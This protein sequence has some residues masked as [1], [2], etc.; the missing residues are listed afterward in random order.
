MTKTIQKCEN[1]AANIRKTIIQMAEY[2]DGDAHWGSALSCV[3]V[4]TVLYNNILNCKLKDTLPSQKDKFILS[5]GHAAMALYAT[6]VEVQIQPREILKNFQQDGSPLGE[7]AIMN[8]QYG[9][10]CSGGSLGLG[11]PMGVGLALAGKRKHMTYQTYVLVGD[12]EM[13][14]GSNWEALMA[15]SQFELDNLTLIIDKNGFQS[16]GANKSI[17]SMENI[18]MKLTAFGWNTTTVNGHSYKELLDVFKREK[19]INQPRAIVVETV[20]GKGISFMEND[21]TWH[22]EILQKDLLAQA[23]KEV[24]CN[25]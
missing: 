1:I 15:A 25:N 7:L 4:L 5:K 17:M 2:C 19:K 23:K 21:N 18:E 12:G 6:L 3:D 24:G 13:N 22:H 10:E 20:K 9:I 8:G 16:D 14:E 11:L